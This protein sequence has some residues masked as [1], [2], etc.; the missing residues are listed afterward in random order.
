M[1]PYSNFLPRSYWYSWLSP[2][3]LFVFVLLVWSFFWKA[4][5]LWQA[6]KKEDRIWFV[7]L[8]IVNTAGL[9]EIGYLFLFSSEAHA[10]RA[11]VKQFFSR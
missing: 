1:I 8:L 11:K 2:G 7:V 5:A 9:F 6:V 4:W 10:N 3:G